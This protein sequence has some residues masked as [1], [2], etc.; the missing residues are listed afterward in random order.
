MTFGLVCVDTEFS[1]I[2][3]VTCKMLKEYRGSPC[4]CTQ[5]R[6]IKE[7]GLHQNQKEIAERME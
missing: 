2:N 5:N 3:G 6:I 4:C 1:S 7:A